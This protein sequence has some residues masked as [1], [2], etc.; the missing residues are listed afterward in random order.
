MLRAT[1]VDLC[2]AHGYVE[3][4]GAAG[5]ARGCVRIPVNITLLRE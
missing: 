1:L 4:A 2:A 3:F 5:S